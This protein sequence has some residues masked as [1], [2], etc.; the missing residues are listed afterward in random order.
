MNVDFFPAADVPELLQTPAYDDFLQYY[1]QALLDHI[2]HSDHVQRALIEKTLN[3]PSEL[4]AKLTEA[5]A[6]I[7]LNEIRK[8]NQ[9]D[10]SM[11]APFAS[12]DMLDLVVKNF[13]MKR[14]IIRESDHQTFP[15]VD[16]VKETDDDLL[17]RYYLFPH[18]LKCGSAKGYEFAALTLDDKPVVTVSSEDN[19]QL[20]VRYQFN[21]NTNNNR[22]IDAFCEKVAPGEVQLHIL[23][24]D[25]LADS[26]LINRV[27]NYIQ[28]RDI[29]EATDTVNV[30]AAQHND[31]NI[32]IRINTTSSP[33]FNPEVIDE[34]L[35]PEFVK[36]SKKS[37]RLGV[38]IRPEYLG[39]IIS[40]AGFTDY[41]VIEPSSVVASDKKYAPNCVSI[42]IDV[43]T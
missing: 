21:T 11:F 15:F 19:N 7:L 28:R 36:Y 10:L 14:Q 23:S 30:V 32:N 1:K 27:N 18:S 37:R 20:V 3:T 35:R 33:Y 16:A 5:N 22:P 4:S 41:E 40:N 13:G 6:Y 8:R 29:K 31:Y 42:N 25:G 43:I 39:A 24:A 34:I 26:E 9:K 2:A 17:K 38:T 12:G